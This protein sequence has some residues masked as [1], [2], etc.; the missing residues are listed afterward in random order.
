V[1]SLREI[2][3]ILLAVAAIGAW[4]QLKAFAIAV[5][6]GL[7]SIVAGPD[8]SVAKENAKILRA[9]ASELAVDPNKKRD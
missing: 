8:D 5:K 3:L 4:Q 7:S 2:D 9:I 6:D 1:N